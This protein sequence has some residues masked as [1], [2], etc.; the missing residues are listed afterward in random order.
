MQKIRVGVLRGG[1]SP[2]Y[3]MSLKT[4]EAVLNS[5]NYDKY[6]TKDIFV[7]KEGLWHVGGFPVKLERVS[8][9]IDVVLNALHGQYGEDG[10][11]QQELES[12]SIPYTGSR[13]IPAA[14]SMNKGLAKHCFE[15]YGIKTPK[16]ITVKRGD[17]I[18]A[19]LL[20]FFREVVGRQVV[21]PLA[22]G[23]SLG[24]V[25]TND[26]EEL[27]RAVAS[28]LEE[29]SAV[30]VE[31]YIRGRELACGVVE[32]LNDKTYPLYPIEIMRDENGILDHRSKYNDVHTRV[33]P[34][35]LDQRRLQEVQNLAILAHKKIGLR[36]YSKADFVLSPKGI[37]LLE[38][39]S[40]PELT[41]ESLVPQALDAAGLDF[42]EFLDYLVTLAL[43]KKE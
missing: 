20:P 40:L 24:V 14:M 22:G 32:G 1:I 28:L 26:F 17:D 21:K 31:E 39:N 27:Y 18:H 42:S 2:E 5:L 12:F 19:A 34:A 4:G 7:D 9:E 8:R 16:G 30:L 15:F 35:N 13:I 23:S 36:H 41:P 33:C 11:V 43:T 3:E 25:L 10:K 37:Y 29:Y 38:I 6:E